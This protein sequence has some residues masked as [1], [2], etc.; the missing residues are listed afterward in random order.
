LKAIAN[1][2]TDFKNAL[3]IACGYASG[4]PNEPVD[5]EQVDRVFETVINKAIKNKVLAEGNKKEKASSPLDMAEHINDPPAKSVKKLFE[6]QNKIEWNTKT[7]QP[8]DC[9]FYDFCNTKN[10]NKFF[11]YK[12]RRAHTKVT[13]F[14]ECMRKD[15]VHLQAITKRELCPKVY[16]KTVNGWKTWDAVTNTT[17]NREKDSF[18]WMDK[19]IMAFIEEN[20]DVQEDDVSTLK[21][22]LKKP[23][24][25]WAVLHDS[26]FKPSDK[27]KLEPTGKT[28]VYV[29]RAVRGIQRRWIT[30]DTTMIT[31]CLDNMC[32][33][34]TYDPSGLEGI[35][36][37]HA[38][39]LALALGRGDNTAL[40]VMKTFGD[41]VEKA[42]IVQEETEASLL[43]AERSRMKAF[44]EYVE[45][46]SELMDKLHNLFDCECE[47]LFARGSDSKLVARKDVAIAEF[48]AA[49]ACDAEAGR[50]VDNALATC[51]RLDEDIQRLR[52]ILT[53][54]TDDHSNAEKKLDDAK[55]S[56]ELTVRKLLRYTT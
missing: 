38:A 41:D 9:T 6:N 7:R 5:Q 23:T 29:G 40:F 18:E 20:A 44:M 1:S 54:V 3:L 30:D 26:D 17:A 34:P 16:I 43:Q 24:L 49:K 12:L 2:E 55:K 28:Q 47:L 42:E 15:V 32:A 48:H 52:G 50:A 25:Y 4:F 21:E 13:L 39:R 31:K 56:H 22:C 51:Q 36:S 10:T 19:S 53:K 35:Q 11:T 37:W 8:V 46:R 45:K 14:E 27:Q 33:M